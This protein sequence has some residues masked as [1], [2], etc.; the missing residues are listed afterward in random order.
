[1]MLAGIRVP[2]ADVLEL[3]RLLRHA[4]LTATAQTLETAY[5]AERAIV[6]LTITD[7]ECILRALED[8]P[9]ASASSARCFCASTSGGFA[10]GP[11]RHAPVR[12]FTYR[13]RCARPDDEGTAGA[14]AE[15]A[16]L[17]DG[18]RSRALVSS[19]TIAAATA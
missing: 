6:A 3:A 13:R 16:R 14:V 10:R 2:N 1:M 4:E 15:A 18:M 17:V 12:N 9:T 11:C 7:R 5:D 8:C 19:R